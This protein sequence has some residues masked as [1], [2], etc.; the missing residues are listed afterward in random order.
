VNLNEVL[1]NF[2]RL[3]GEKRV[4]L[5]QNPHFYEMLPTSAEEY[6]DEF[7]FDP[8][9]LETDRS[10]PTDY[11]TKAEAERIAV[12]TD[13]LGPAGRVYLEIDKKNPRVF[14]NVWAPKKAIIFKG[15]SLCYPF[16][17]AL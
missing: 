3:P 15:S 5:K 16:F 17:L 14:G 12:L 8:I 9:E 1:W 2:S 13:K 4:T 7:Q 10:N 6:H 11:K